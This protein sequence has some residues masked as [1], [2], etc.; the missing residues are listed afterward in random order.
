L[1]GVGLCPRGLPSSRA[2]F[3][4]DNPVAAGDDVA[5][6]VNDDGDGEEESGPSHMEQKAAPGTLTKVHAPHAGPDESASSAQPIW[7][8]VVPV[9]LD[10]ERG[11]SDGSSV[12][13]G[14]VCGALFSTAAPLAP[15]LLLLLRLVVVTLLLLPVLILVLLLTILLLLLLL[16]PQKLVMGFGLTSFMAVEQSSPP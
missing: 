4:L 9:A 16:L 15:A 3:A 14:A 13:G 11:P 7:E 2:L 5:A 1:F 12:A 8:A 10:C 6:V